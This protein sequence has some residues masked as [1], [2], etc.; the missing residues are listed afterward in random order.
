M[1][2]RHEAVSTRAGQALA[3]R[4]AHA[5]AARG[6]SV[7]ALAREVGVSS[8]LISAI[9]HG[10]A[11]PSA[12]NLYAIAAELELSI[13]E[14]IFG[15]PRVP[16]GTEGGPSASDGHGDPAGPVL[17]AGERPTITLD[18]GV[19]WQR[20]TPQHEPGVDVLRTTYAVGGVSDRDHA[21]VRHAGHE[22][23]LIL[24]GRLE[25]QI[26]AQREDLVEGDA[27]SFASTTPHLL[28][29]AG[30]TP[31]ETVWFVLGRDEA[32]GPDHEPAAH[33]TPATAVLRAADRSVTHTGSGVRVERLT[34]RPEPGIAFEVMTF[35]PG[36]TSTPDGTLARRAGH[37][38][39]LV[40]SGRLQVAIAFERHELGPGD[41]ISFA[42]TTPHLVVNP[43]TEPAQAV[44]FAATP[45]R[46]RGAPA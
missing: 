23:G 46:L 27:I 9:E 37:E 45:E 32:A 36:A 7:R 19:T 41:S 43:G 2:E 15:A 34:P 17:R 11:Q 10:R 14:L 26:G 29:N 28:R 13:D 25:T 39:G 42:A 16:A 35:A 40:L 22:W 12:A 5:R 4:L 18:T 24:S 38:W 3:A 21:M 44:W 1:A 8:S 6:L 33:A 31:V 20:L 30:D